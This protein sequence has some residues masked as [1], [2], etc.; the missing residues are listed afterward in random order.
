[1]L[2]TQLRRAT[3]R[4]S[5]ASARMPTLYRRRKATPQRQK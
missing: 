1:L 3:S 2:R 4:I 5:D